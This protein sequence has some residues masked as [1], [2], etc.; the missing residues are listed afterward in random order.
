MLA[1][2]GA[3]EVDLEPDAAERDAGLSDSGLEEADAPLPSDAAEP[4]DVPVV[5]LD[6]GDVFVDA[7]ADGGIDGGPVEVDAGE[8]EDPRVIEATYRVLHWNIAGGKEN[9]CATAG[10]T[11]AVRRFVRDNDVDFVGLNE[12]CPSQFASIRDDLRNLWGL[13]DGNRFAAFVGDGTGRVVGNA[14]YSRFGLREVESQKVGEDRYGDRNL[15]CGEIAGQRQLRLCGTHLTPGDATAR[16]QLGRVLTQIERWWTRDRDTV[17]LT[18]DLNIHPNDSGLNSVYSAEAN[19]PNNPNNR[20]RYREVDDNDP[21]HCRGYGERSVPSTGG[22][23]CGM[24]GKIDFIFA[25]ENRIVDDRY[26]GDT[27]NIPDDCTGVCSDH[28]PV[29]G[30]LRLRVRND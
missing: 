8:E 14:I 5:R 26:A 3:G 28:R 12:V 4:L 24:G 22:G 6:G 7:G 10:I 17:I 2:C 19:T 23:P 15:L 29:F 20:G 9:A 18:G 16:V 27:F 11:R 21:D 1:A 30:R 13:E 25:R